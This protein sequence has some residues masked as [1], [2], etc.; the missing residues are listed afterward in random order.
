MNARLQQQID[1]IIEIDKLK[2][3]FRRS[4]LIDQSRHENDAEHSW[5]LAMMALVL[6]EHATEQIDIARVVKMVVIH[7]IVEVDAG[8]VFL[9]DEEATKNKAVREQQAA[10]RLFGMLPADQASDFRATWEEFEARQTAEARF[11]AALDRLQP[12]IHHIQSK[13]KTWQEHGVTLDRVMQR[14]SHIADA[15][16]ALWE[17]AQSLIQH[18]VAEGYLKSE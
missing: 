15:S 7:D 11:A 4:Y 9:Y 17:Y 5:H 6:A 13:G 18:A 12:L 1:F 2:Q 8:D 10:E 14:N 3:V 16:P